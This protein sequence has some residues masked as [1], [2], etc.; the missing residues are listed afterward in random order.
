[1]PDEGVGGGIDE[2]TVVSALVSPRMRNEKVELRTRQNKRASYDLQAEITITRAT[3][4]SLIENKLFRAASE[5]RCHVFNSKRGGWNNVVKLNTS[6]LHVHG[7][8]TVVA[9][10]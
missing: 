6:T 5:I 4:I 3:K 8:A 7:L 10:G 2:A 1:M 9:G